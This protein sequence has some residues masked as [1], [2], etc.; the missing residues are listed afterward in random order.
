MDEKLNPK[1]QHGSWPTGNHAEPSSYP[2]HFCTKQVDN[3]CQAEAGKQTIH[4]T[5]MMKEKKF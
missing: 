2:L 3:P 1:D 4:R 5:N